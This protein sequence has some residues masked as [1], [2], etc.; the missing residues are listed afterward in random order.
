[1]RGIDFPLSMFGA[2]SVQLGRYLEH[3]GWVVFEDVF[4]IWSC[5]HQNREQH[6]MARRQAELELAR[7]GQVET[8]KAVAR[9][10]MALGVSS[11]P[12]GLRRDSLAARPTAR[13]ARGTRGTTDH[14][15][16]PSLA[17]SP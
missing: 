13:R 12:P 3:V 10:S 1:V 9:S 11:E 16:E 6:V 15:P 7:Q 5:A 4:L 17:I 8:L 14:Q 2:S